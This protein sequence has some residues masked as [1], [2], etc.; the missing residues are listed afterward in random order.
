MESTVDFFDL[1]IR[2][3]ERLRQLLKDTQSDNLDETAKYDFGDFCEDSVLFPQSHE[4]SLKMRGFEKPKRKRG[5]PPKLP[6]EELEAQRLKAEEEFLAKQRKEAQE[7]REIEESLEE[8]RRKRRV[9]IPARFQSVV[10]GK[11]L[12]KAYV[13]EGV[14]DK[15][16]IS[17][18][19]DNAP[20]I[21]NATDGDEGR[22]SQIIG[23]L[24]SSDGVVLS[25]LVVTQKTQFHRKGRV[26]RLKTRFM[27][28][29]CSKSFSQELR[30]LTHR[31][32]HQNVR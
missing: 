14:I 32:T 30:F 1:I 15:T 28:D 10:Q 12:E 6:P 7:L 17:D 9:R 31:A 29:V 21:E 13:A 20:I 16:D 3:Q 8:G 19:E 23:H 22:G 26:A 5:R 25:D 11:E 27:C 4:L 18:T 24:K 2:G